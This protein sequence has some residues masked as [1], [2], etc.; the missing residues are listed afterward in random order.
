MAPPSP[1]DMRDVLAEDLRLA[2]LVAL[3]LLVGSGVSL[4]DDFNLSVTSSDW[5]SLPGPYTL[6]LV[7]AGNVTAFWRGGLPG[8]LRP[9]LP[10]C[11][12][13]RISP[14]SATRPPPR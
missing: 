7:L 11:T 4:E 2:L 9:R 6:L 5:S 1:A 10:A 13:D 3:L 14:C 8:G 12:G